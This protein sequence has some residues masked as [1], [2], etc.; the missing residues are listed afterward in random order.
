MTTV[1]QIAMRT[2]RDVSKPIPINQLTKPGISLNSLVFEGDGYVM[3]ALDDVATLLRVGMK[4]FMID[5]YWNEFTS[6]WQLCPA[7]FPSNITDV[8]AT[9]DLSWNTLQYT[10]QPTLTIE[11]LMQVFNNYI[12]ATNTNMNVDLIEILINLK[13]IQSKRTNTTLYS[14]SMLNQM[15]NSTL[16]ST[17]SSLGSYVFTPNDFH[18]YQENLQI[19]QYSNFYNS[20]STIL[21]SLSTVLLSDFRRILVNVVSNELVNSTRKYEISSEDTSV[22]FFSGISVNTT[23]LDNNDD[24]IKSCE[25]IAPYGLNSS[26]SIEFFD[27]LALNTNFQYVIDN[28]AYPFTNETYQQFI[29]CGN[30]PILNSTYYDFSLE[31]TDYLGE[32]VNNFLPISFWSWAPGEP[33]SYNSNINDTH[34][35]LGNLT[36]DFEGSQLAYKCVVF[37]K[38]GWRVDNCYRS[39]QYACQNLHSPNDW[40]I[41]KDSRKEYFQ[42]YK[43]SCPNGYILSLPMSSIESASLSDAIEDQN[44]T[45]PIWID[46][47]DITVA[48]CFVSGGPYADCPYQ[49]TVSEARLVR[50]IAPSFIVAVLVLFMIIIEKIFRVNPIQTNRK[51]YWK[52]V[53]Q[54]YNEKHGFEGVPS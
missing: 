8:N 26:D 5:L 27:E 42:A 35:Q 23:I 36:S 17:I 24:T 54:E 22:I 31:A 48:G 37:D 12:V 39:Y 9:V 2:Q 33:S 11:K 51:R 1:M 40:I 25:N 49:K 3:D 52:R 44:A 53:V 16:N 29:R 32:I 28:D 14:N 6:I 38:D 19:N 47:N 18:N 13:S 7:P 50:L 20:T 43:E 4:T 46:L 15:G 21:P 45:Y 41:P 10:C 30:T 34:S